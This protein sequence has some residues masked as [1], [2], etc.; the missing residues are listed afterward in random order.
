MILQS[1]IDSRLV[2]GQVIEAWLPHLNVRRLVVAD[3]EA[4]GDPL[5]R[6]VMG[7]AVPPQVHVVLERVASLDFSAYAK[8]SVPTLVLFRD[9][10]AVVSARAHGLPNGLLNVGNVHAAPGKTAHSRS[11]FLSDEEKDALNAMRQGGMD[12]H[13][14]A[15]PTEKATLLVH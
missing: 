1:R 4:A 7:M 12:V 11:V 15:V 8:D 2:H 10:A 3:D 14:Q 9:V 13:L 5:A 6:T